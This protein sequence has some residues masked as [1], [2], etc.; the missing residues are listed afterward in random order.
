M[1]SN[2]LRREKVDLEGSPNEKTDVFHNEHPRGGLSADE[3]EFL[4]TFPDDRKKKI[5]RKVDVRF[6][7]SYTWHFT[8]ESSA[9][10]DPYACTAVLD[11]LS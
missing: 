2:Q 9:T 1:S 10:I 3:F 8:N 11:R 6:S 4:Q 7:S 5:L